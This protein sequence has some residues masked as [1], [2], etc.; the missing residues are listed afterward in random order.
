MRKEQHMVQKDG[1]NFEN[2]QARTMYEELK[3]IQGNRMD[4]QAEPDAVITVEMM[5][6]YLEI[7]KSI[8]R[9]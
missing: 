1:Y 9:E 6:R 2:E 5:E 4:L 3:S 7:A 8:A